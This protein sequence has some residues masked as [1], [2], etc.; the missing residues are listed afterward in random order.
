MAEM[1]CG[2]FVI[3]LPCIPKIIKETG[4]VGHIK[5]LTKGSGRGSYGSYHQSHELESDRYTGKSSD[6]AGMHKLDHD[7]HMSALE[8]S[9]STERLHDGVRGL[10]ITRT[11]QFAITEG[12][13]VKAGGGADVGFTNYRAP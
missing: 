9:E 7:V 12:D 4:I 13:A 3:C 8:P 2:F 11:T 1:T 6:R 10:E 5:K